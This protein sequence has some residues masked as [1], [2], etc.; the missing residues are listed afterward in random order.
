MSL[1]TTLEALGNQVRRLSGKTNKMTLDAMT[2]ALSGV[3]VGSNVSGADAVITDV[4]SGKKFVGA[5]GVLE[6]GSMINRGAVSQTLDTSTKTYNIPAGYHNGGGKVQIET[7][8]KSVTPSAS[9]Q[10]VYPDAGK[11]LSAVT[12]AASSGRTVYEGATTTSGSMKITVGTGVTLSENDTFFACPVSVSGEPVGYSDV[13]ISV[14]KYGG[15]VY[16][17]SSDVAFDDEGNTG[18]SA[19]MSSGIS[20]TYS[21]NNITVKPTAG[22]TLASGE[23]RWVLIK[24]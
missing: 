4:L 19:T 9:A 10:T 20:V 5:N 23:W 6:T 13:F 11:V 1:K 21:G 14:I 16:A 22:S 18:P 12:V 7:Q 24:N 3:N 17:A 15:V 2:Q 8:T